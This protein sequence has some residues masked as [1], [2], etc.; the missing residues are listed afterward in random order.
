MSC[1]KYFNSPTEIGLRTNPV[2]NYC[3][4][5]KPDGSQM[6]FKDW[7][8]Y[9]AN[10]DNSHQSCTNLF[11]NKIYSGPN[12]TFSPENFNQV[13]VDFNYIFSKYFDP[14]NSTGSG[15]HLFTSPGQE[16]YD[17]FQNTII[18]ACSNNPQYGLQGACQQVA[19]QMCSNCSTQ[20]IISNNDLLKL[21]GCN[22]SS[23]ENI[24]EYSNIQPA[25]DPLCISEQVSK[26]RDP[27]SGDIEICTSTVC[28]INDIS[29]KTSNSGI[30]NFSQICPQCDS[31]G[32]RCIVDSSIPNITGL[33]SFTQYCGDNSVCLNIDPITQ[34]STVIP[35]ND[36]IDVLTPETYFLPINLWVWITFFIILIL[37]FL[38]I[39]TYYYN[40]NLDNKKIK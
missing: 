22:K 26:K 10:I 38:V 31:G 24:P 13:V 32:C 35:C 37:A 16:G 40:K 29:I 19:S 2:E 4:G 8:S 25:C 21:C 7:K 12:R 1:V 15:G 36:V 5:L 27:I 30:L 18:S 9:W 39:L 14:N 20:E 6:S 33:D 3:M 17:S 34:Q 23:L 11:N 28:V